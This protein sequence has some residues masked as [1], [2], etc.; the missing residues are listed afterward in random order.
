M[1]AVGTAHA[2]SEPSF[3]FPLET[4]KPLTETATMPTPIYVEWD[5]REGRIDARLFIASHMGIT[6]CE[7][8]RHEAEVSEIESD[9]EIDAAERE[10]RLKYMDENPFQY[11][12]GDDDEIY[13]DMTGER[14]PNGMYAYAH[15]GD[16]FLGAHVDLPGD[17]SPEER[18][19]VWSDFKATLEANGFAPEWLHGPIANDEVES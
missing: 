6:D 2:L 10:R 4:F 8:G 15:E 16:L 13:T 14:I 5:R 19:E 7:I 1:V 12:P 18:A 17:A 3:S 9:S 11:E